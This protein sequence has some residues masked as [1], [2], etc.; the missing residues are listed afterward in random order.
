MG[1]S[2][3]AYG[4]GMMG[5]EAIPNAAPSNP[6]G[7]SPQNRGSSVTPGGMMGGGGMMGDSGPR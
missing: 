1:G 3:S 5:I 6:S 2:G 7:T 4:R